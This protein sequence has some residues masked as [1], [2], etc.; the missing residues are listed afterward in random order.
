MDF[1]QNIVGS[2][3]QVIGQ[4]CDATYY[5]PYFFEQNCRESK[6]E[7]TVPCHLQIGNPT[8]RRMNENLREITE[9][10]DSCGNKEQCFTFLVKEVHNG[11]DPTVHSTA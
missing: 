11:T 4:P 3:R 7:V 8:L 9:V 5:M 10:F 1:H 6:T 2:T